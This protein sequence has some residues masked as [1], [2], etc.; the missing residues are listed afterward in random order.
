[1][2]EQPT[3]TKHPRR[4]VARTVAAIA[5]AMFL[6]LPEILAVVGPKAVPW[7]VGIAAVAG[8]V[9]KVLTIPRVNRALQVSRVLAWLAPEPRK[10][11]GPS[12]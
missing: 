3:Q 6:A 2:S 1:M 4:A 10:D 5:V 9:T 11:V 8:G 7:L 12:S